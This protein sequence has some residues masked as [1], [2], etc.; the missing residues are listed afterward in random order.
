MAAC[1]TSRQPINSGATGVVDLTVWIVLAPNDI[2]GDLSNRGCRM[3]GAEVTAFINAL[4]ANSGIYGG[5]TVF[6]WTGVPVVVHDQLIPSGN[7]TQDEA[8]W[9]NPSYLM[10]QN[11]YFDP[12][13]VNIYFVGNVQPGGAANPRE[14]YAATADPGTPGAFQHFPAFIYLNDGGYETPFGFLPTDTPALVVSYHVLEHELTHY[15]GRF[16][17]RQFPETG[18]IYDA[19]EHDIATPAPRNNILRANAPVPDPLVIPGSATTGSS[20]KREIWDR[21]S[22]GLWNNP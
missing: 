2:L 9:T 20:E 18:S 4:R 7:R 6:N 8:W 11:E 17:N 15:F 1:S 14:G 16:R 22:A 21:I 10:W 3:T 13:T 5:N 19:G 12:N